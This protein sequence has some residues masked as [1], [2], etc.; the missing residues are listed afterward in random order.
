MKSLRLVKDV[1]GVKLGEKSLVFLGV[2]ISA[3]IYF[4]KH[5][6]FKR[7]ELGSSYAAYFGKGEVVEVDIV[8]VFDCEQEASEKEAV[9]VEFVEGEFLFGHV[10]AVEV[11]QGD[12]EGLGG[13][14]S[15]LVESLQVFF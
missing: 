11:D 7:E 2:D 6:Q 15:V 4:L 9:D 12:D 8:V 14:M 5:F 1:I 10:V 3:E 13:K